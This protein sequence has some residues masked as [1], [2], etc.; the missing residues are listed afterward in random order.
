MRVIRGV[1]SIGM[2]L[3]TCTIPGSPKEVRIGDGKAELGLGIHG[4]AG[5][6][7]VAFT[8]ARAAMGM[9]VEKLAPHLGAGPHVALLNNLGGTTPLEMAIL[10]EELAQSAIGGRISH[11]VGPAPLMT[12]LD[13]RGFSVSLLPLQDEAGLAATVACPAWPGLQPFGAVLALPLPDGLA[14]IKPIPSEN[15]AVRAF[16]ATHK[17]TP[18]EAVADLCHAVL[19]LNE[20]VYVD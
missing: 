10:T 3:D 17:G 7:Q 14:P 9:V 19:N 16:L 4:E 8:G 13:M 2:S 11:L 6:E 18:A 1:V 20:F 5:I 15:A 12:S